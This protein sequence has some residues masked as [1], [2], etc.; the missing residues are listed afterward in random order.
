MIRTPLIALLSA[1][2][3]TFTGIAGEEM[4]PAA[5]PGMETAPVADD[6][7]EFTLGLD[8]W[9]LQV[10]LG[11]TNSSIG[12]DHNIFLGFDDIISNMDWYI[13]LGAD[14]RYGRF[15]I[16]PEVQATKLSG[17]A[18]TPGPLFDTADV[19]LTMAIWNLPV[20]YRVVDQ[21]NLSLDVLAGA[22]YLYVDTDVSLRGGVGGAA[23]SESTSRAW[24]GIVGLRLQQQI[25]EKLFYSVYGDIGTGDSDL[26]WQVL[27]TLG[28]NITD[29]F[30]ILAGYRY[31]TWELSDGAS[32]VN[33]TA[34][35][36][37]IHFTW[38][39]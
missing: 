4:M 10:N 35:G 7:F 37:V 31:A 32:D 33:L 18:T 8:I 38:T 14:L 13:P 27:A 29:S 34:S 6:D 19:E 24:D 15:G 17:A 5:E 16:L 30:S 36:P 12:L 20:Y 9:I 3:L 2:S 26:T 1:F 11:I 39:F 22:R 21:S 25:A 23:E 28:Y